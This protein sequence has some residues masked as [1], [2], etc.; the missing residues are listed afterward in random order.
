MV[1]RIQPAKILETMRRIWR[2]G[3]PLSLTLMAEMIIVI[4]DS[5]FAGNISYIALA[6]VSLA[7][8]AFYIFLL[9]LIGFEAGS[10][11]RAGQAYGAN[12]YKRMLYC[13]RQGIALCLVIALPCSIILFNISPLLIKLGQQPEVVALSK[14]YL[15][16]FSWVL[17]FQLLIILLR[18]YYAVINQPWKSVWPVCVTLILNAGLNY[19]LAF[20]NFGFP[21]MG[22]SGI[23]L[24]SLISNIALLGLMLMSV[25]RQNSLYLLNIFTFSL[26]FDRDLVRLFLISLPIGM[27]L[28]L[29]EAFF[30]GTNLLAGSLGAAEQAAHQILFNAIGASFLFNSGIGMAVSIIIGKHIGANNYSRILDT[31]ACGFLIVLMCSLPF[32]IVL[33]FFDDQWIMVYLDDSARSNAKVIFLVKSA[34]WIAIVSLFI[35]ACYLIVM[36]T[37]RGMLDTA[38]ASI[39]ALVSYW[40]IAAPLAYWACLHKPFAFIWIWL[41]ILLAST[42]LTV[43]VSIRLGIRIRHINRHRHGYQLTRSVKVNL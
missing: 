35:D 31:A 23:G 41:S 34:I 29:E 8:S 14:E 5:L 21:Y 20:G 2:L 27:T 3:L 16:W 32:A 9:L 11:I 42:L 13:F 39:S 18:G 6:A 15:F 36:D 40:L 37:L 22:I 30:S 4:V 33:S 19:C 17:P 24:A 25:G 12:D 7:A 38:Y 10:T 28:L 1:T 26:W 43:L